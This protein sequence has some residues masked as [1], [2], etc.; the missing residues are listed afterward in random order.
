MT[1]AL[2]G[3]GEFARKSLLSPKALR[4]YDELGLLRPASVDPDTGYR[5]YSEGQ[6]NSASRI[7]RRGKRG[8]RRAG[9]VVPAGSGQP[10]GRARGR[11]PALALRTEPAH[12]EA[13]IDLGK[14]EMTPPQWQLASKALLSWVT[15]QQRR[16][17]DLGIRVTFHATKPVT[18]A[19]RPDCDFA[20]PLG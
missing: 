13:Y 2:M 16:P 3:I 1:V 17:G 20:L 8:Q 15:A 14:A 4:L 19:S 9:R 12:E 11:F 6:L 10:G 18:A 5:W 7:L